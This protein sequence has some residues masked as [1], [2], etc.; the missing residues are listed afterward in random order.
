MILVGKAAHPE[1]SPSC[2]NAV[3]PRPC[4][5]EGGKK[6]KSIFCLTLI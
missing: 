4:Q 3:S 6:E 1:N 2:G 5:S